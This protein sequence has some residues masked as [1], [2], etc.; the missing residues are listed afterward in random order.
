MRTI[1]VT[2]P[3]G[4]GL[5]ERLTALGWRALAIPT[6][7]IRPAE[8]GGAF[9]T[10]LARLGEF[11]WIILTSANGARA[12]LDGLRRLGLDLPAGP[13]WAAVG[14]A[15]AAALE[16]GGAHVSLVP[17]RHLG[18]AI[19]EALGDLSGKRILLPRADAASPELPRL[20]RARGAL[21][22]DVTAYRTIEGPE[23]SREPLLRALRDGVDGVIFTSGSAVHGFVALAGSAQPLRGLLV[24]CIGPVTASAARAEGVEPAVVADDHTTDGVIAAL[25]E[26]L[27]ARRR[28]ASD[29]PSPV[30]RRSTGGESR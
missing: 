23:E 15:T 25:A 18:A 20:L 22:E 3:D 21:V 5:A 19:A 13:R 30:R 26:A 1:L 6:V 27:P 12:V 4:E 16:E 29:T 28:A 7:A 14:P 24:A 8:P 11:E 9:D 10:A 17:R 2:R